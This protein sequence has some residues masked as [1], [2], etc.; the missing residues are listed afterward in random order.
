MKEVSFFNYVFRRY[1]AFRGAVVFLFCALLLAV[2]FLFS[3]VK[4]T[5]P[6]ISSITPS[7][8]SENSVIHLAGNHFGSEKEDDSY[9]EISGNRLLPSLYVS[10]SEKKIEFKIPSDVD[11]AIVRVRTKS[12]KSNPVFFVN[13]STVPRAAVFSGRYRPLISSFEPSYPAVGEVCRIRGKYFG[14]KTGRVFFSASR[15][16]T[17]GDRQNFDEFLPFVECSD[18]EEWDNDEIILRVPDGA[19]SGEFF[20][21]VSSV[22][23][24][25]SY[26][27][28]KDFS[29]KRY[30]SPMNYSLRTEVSLAFPKEVRDEE[31]YL[32]LRMP[33]PMEVASNYNVSAAM[34]SEGAIHTD[35]NSTVLYRVKA[36]SE[37]AKRTF[38]AD[39]TL[40]CYEINT[41]IDFDKIGSYKDTDK[42][43]YDK[44][45]A[46]LEGISL[47]KEKLAKLAEKAAAKER[48]PAKVAKAVY[49][50]MANKYTLLS[51]AR[52]TDAN[53]ADLVKYS[54][55]DAWDFAHLYAAILRERGVMCA[56]AGGILVKREGGQLVSRPH[57]W[58]MVWLPSCGWVPVDTAL[59][60]TGERERE[61]YFANQDNRHVLFSL[62]FNRVKSVAEGNKTVF[63]R[64]SYALQS[65][66]EEASSGVNAYS[67]YWSEPVITA[68]Y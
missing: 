10:W 51:H 5:A 66:W 47:S 1:P 67:S 6:L 32:L 68:L 29:H 3:H 8:G 40:R 19:V 11:G 63:R 21:M 44:N 42:A 26:I 12:G 28:I 4:R 50:Y 18:Y 48:N 37:E 49:E 27:N 43:F 45:T 61:Y 35:F 22:K 13:E 58:N 65:V 17:E 33:R 46:S 38:T 59:A 23:S 36:K 54:M 41:E 30:I 14:N 7:V 39:F 24:P 34:M 53:A 31:A 2:F 15:E 9:V 62:G 52:A 57:W 56:L 16:E 60:T 55:G 64:R 25:L 20:V